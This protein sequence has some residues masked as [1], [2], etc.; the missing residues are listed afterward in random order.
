MDKGINTDFLSRKVKSY[1]KKTKS[2]PPKQNNNP[3]HKTLDNSSFLGSL[4]QTKQPL[5]L[6]NLMYYEEEEMAKNIM[7]RPFITSAVLALAST[8]VQAN[9]SGID[10]NLGINP[11]AGGMAGAAYTRPEESTAAIF[12]NPATLTQFKGYNMNF[13]ASYLMIDATNDQ[14][15]SGPTGTFENHSVSAADSYLIPSFGLSVELAEGL[16]LGLGLET[17]GGLGADYRDDPIQLTA[18]AAPSLGFPT[19]VSLPVLIEL[20]SFN[21]NIGLGYEVTEKLS[22][23]VSG[24]IGFGMFQF[25]TAGP[26]SG[27]TAFGAATGNP[28]LT[29]FGGTTAS[30]HDIGIGASLGATYALTA[31][32]MLSAT[33]KSEV[34][35]NFEN[36]VHSTVAPGNG[37]QDL[38][39]QTPMEV[40]VGVSTEE[41]F[42]P[43]LLAELDLIWKDLSKASTLQDV[44]DDQL[45]A[46]LGARYT[47]GD[48]VFRLGYKWVEPQ[49]LSANQA[50]N[51]IGTLQGVG[52]LPLGATA[53]MAGFGAVADDLLGI[54]Q[55]TLTPVIMEHTLSFGV[56]YNVSE[57]IRIDGYV[58]HAFKGHE[59]RYTPSL[60]GLAGL[61]ASE[62]EANTSTT[63]AG[64]GINI[65]LP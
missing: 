10:L 18:G 26:T 41:L 2:K 1:Q 33:I 47:T 4:Q 61:P 57:T 19:P 15:F 29:D 45:T 62:L 59:K 48:W 58:S 39:I 27:I 11:A 65:A 22:V 60:N 3:A 49:Q 37:W 30:V 28:G 35:Y 43:G 36:G 20:I 6:L 53:D 46:A 24:T 63:W 16:V 34:E 21:A 42:L 5:G 17:D 40:I 56:G 13:G 7:K 25:G 23:G 12:G 38:T 54:V 9:F 55:T 51:A 44:W 64:L 31:R 52:S 14:R 50:G 8:S 32:T